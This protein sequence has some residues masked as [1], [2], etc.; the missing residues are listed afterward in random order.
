ML[1]SLTLQIAPCM[2]QEFLG[3]RTIV[4]MS[5]PVS[6]VN[7]QTHRA[8]GNILLRLLLQMTLCS[9]E[10]WSVILSQILPS[11]PWMRSSTVLAVSEA[12]QHVS[13]AQASRMAL[14]SAGIV[15]AG[16]A[17]GKRWSNMLRT[18]IP[19]SCFTVRFLLRFRFSAASSGPNSGRSSRS[20]AL[21]CHR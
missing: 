8:H 18:I 17:V 4:T 6:V 5:A 2:A 19:V 13:P 12:A 3:L 7:E 11:R 14:S 21:A 1:G 15:V 20:Y 16:N 10:G 9:L